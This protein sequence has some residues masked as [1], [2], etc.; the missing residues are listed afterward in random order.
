M[1]QMGWRYKGR[2]WLH[3]ELLEYAKDY[4]AHFPYSPEILSAMFPEQ[5]RAFYSPTMLTGCPRQE[6]LKRET[7]F[8][9]EP[10]KVYKAWRGTLAHTMLEHLRHEQGAILEKRFDAVLPLGDGRGVLLRGKPDKVL[11]EQGLVI[12][13]KTL[14]EVIS[15]PKETWTPQLSSYKWLLHHNGVEVE[16]GIIQQI[17]MD[18]AKMI[19]V[20]LW[21]LESTEAWLR[22]RMLK[23]VGVLEREYD[24]EHLPPMLDYAIDNNAWLC[25]TP[26]G[27]G[28]AWCPVAEACFALAHKGI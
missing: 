14:K 12:D 8:Y 6:V 10:E 24:L 19:D 27:G 15:V 4:P 23:F 20:E 22:G 26:K 28:K 16:R 21:D 3:K 18:E 2:D 11:P 9:P 5:E 17:S 7:D 25:R 13:Y 1:G